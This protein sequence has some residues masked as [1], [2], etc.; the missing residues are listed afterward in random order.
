MKINKQ[1]EQFSDISEQ[2]GNENE[3]GSFRNSS[4]LNEI[5]EELRSGDMRILLIRI[6][7]WISNHKIAVA[8]AGGVFLLFGLLMNRYISFVAGLAFVGIGAGISKLDDS[9]PYF[10][11]IVGFA[12]FVI[13]Y[14]AM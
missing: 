9:D 12:I 5:K 10:L 2:L 1:N 4:N 7:Y 14:V 3:G 11:Y 8:I 6:G 13:P